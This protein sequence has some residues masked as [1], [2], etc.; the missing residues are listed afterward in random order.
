MIEKISTDR[1]HA[2]AAADRRR[3]GS[4]LVKNAD[5]GNGTGVRPRASRRRGKKGSAIDRLMAGAHELYSEMNYVFRTKRLAVDKPLVVLVIALLVMG[6]VMVYSSSYVYAFYHNDGNSYYFIQ[7]QVM[8]ALA[9]LA[10]MIVISAVPPRLLRGRFTW[11]LFGLT[12]VLLIAVFFARAKNGVHRW[13]LGFQP[14][15]IAKF[16]VILVCADYIAANYRAIS[17]CTYHSLEEKQR[18]NRT[19]L[20]H[21][22]YAMKQNL[23]T[24]VLPAMIFL[25]MLG[26]V[27]KEPHLS[28]TVL[29]VM[30]IATQML[31]G[32]T[33]YEYFILV[34]S[35]IAVGL[36]LVAFTSLIPYGATR[37]A[38]WKD[39][40]VD[41]RGAGWQNIQSLYAIS[42]GG[43]FGV[44]LG[45][46]RQKY[47]YISEPQNDFIFA[48]VCEELG[49]V[50]AV[51]IILLFT[52]FVWR[53]IVISISHPDRF[54]RLV[55]IGISTQIAYQV[56]L[57]V[58]VVTNLIPNTGISLPF[59]SAGGT[60][61]TVLLAE[62]GV[63][64]AISRSSPKKLI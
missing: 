36:Y 55:G 62:I 5:S 22:W 3:S 40:F 56:I 63:L 15:E 14:T 61:L 43:L 60:S 31:I 10:L 29:L 51:C 30:I 42:S 16:V 25:P 33:R 7:R 12:H 1:Y 50:G 9:G 28:C 44:G 45:N 18:V 17:G 57:N 24:G 21:W 23:V 52:L 49:L 19:K 35:L 48:V 59:F 37:F 27:I 46:S 58:C 4:G 20:S 64:L 41:P 34:F 13:I 2:D 54:A 53:G 39:P 47:L 8:F 6:L 38:V 11:I 32:G 26:L